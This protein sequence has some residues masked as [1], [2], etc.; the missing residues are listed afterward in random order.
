MFYTSRYSICRILFFFSFSLDVTVEWPYLTNE[1]RDGLIKNVVTEKLG[2]TPKKDVN[3][4]SL[5]QSCKE[6][7][8]FRAKVKAVPMTTDE[9]ALRHKGYT[10]QRVSPLSND[11]SCNV[12]KEF[13][14]FDND[15][16]AP[17]R[18]TTAVL[19]GTANEP[20]TVVAMGDV[21]TIR[22]NDDT[23]SRTESEAEAK[24]EESKERDNKKK[25][26]LV[27]GTVYMIR[28]AELSV[29]EHADSS[30]SRSS[31]VANDLRVIKGITAGH[32]TRVVRK[33]AFFFANT[34][35]HEWQRLKEF[36]CKEKGEEELWR[37]ISEGETLDV[38]GR[39]RLLGQMK[40]ATITAQDTAEVGETD[41]EDEVNIKGLIKE[42]KPR[43]L[44]L[45]RDTEEK[46]Q[47][48]LLALEGGAK[49]PVLKPSESQSELIGEVKRLVERITSEEKWEAAMDG[50]GEPS[51]MSAKKV[52]VDSQESSEEED[53]KKKKKKKKK[54]E[55]RDSNNNSE[56]ETKGTNAQG[57]K[58]GKTNENDMKKEEEEEC[59]GDGGGSY[60][61]EDDDDD[62][63]YI[64]VNVNVKKKVK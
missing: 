47:A 30:N 61:E 23:N 19:V 58:E 43:T 56:T 27:R 52:R 63:I 21:V 11:D 51:E 24:E 64:D 2:P 5:V 25:N 8:P 3:I 50:Y 44:S 17:N 28:E 60:S 4:D 35:D 45:A 57:D 40:R 53:E 29:L 59:D 33:K 41:E 22:I 26:T 32:V 55:E 39:R 16:Y 48:P 9:A 7:Y 31:D 36:L 12:Y 15:R 46:R 42:R 10:V 38:R 13:K 49:R 18:Y 62:D 20:D 6:V 54:E 37:W 1:E 34:G 14:V